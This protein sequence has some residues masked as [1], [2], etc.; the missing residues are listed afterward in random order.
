MKIATFLFITLIPTIPGTYGFQFIADKI[1]RDIRG[2]QNTANFIVQSL[3]NPFNNK[4]GPNTNSQY[5]Q[6]THPNSQDTSSC[7]ATIGQNLQTEIQSY[8]SA[9]DVIVA[10][11]L[12]GPFKGRAFNNLANMTDN[13][14]H[15]MLG[16]EGL[17]QA[18]DF[19]VD[20][21][22]RYGLE[23]V[24]AEN[25]PISS[26][27]WVRGEEHAM[28]LTPRRKKIAVLGFGGSVG[29][30]P[31]GVEA[32]VLVVRSFSELEQHAGQVSILV[33]P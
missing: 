26:N 10:A 21:M 2:F 11:V 9:V 29:T 16:S 18:V 14:G 8:K 4:V 24:R 15:R 28:L 12:N 19:M 3:F 6:Q 33:L 27:S 32:P 17:N 20:K 7:R 5:T 1:G 30:A 25:V 23:N 13:I 22:K 31:S